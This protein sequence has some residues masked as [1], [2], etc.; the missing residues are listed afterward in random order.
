M[1]TDAERS[2]INDGSHSSLLELSDAKAT[3]PARSS[4]VDVATKEVESEAVEEKPKK[5]LKFW[6]CI[7]SIMICTFIMS[8]DL[9]RPIKHTTALKNFINLHNKSG[10]STA[11]PVIIHDLSGS[12]FEWVGSAYAL[13]ATAFMPLSG[14]LAGVSSL[15]L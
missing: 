6:M 2:S 12:Q 9:V 10:T 11:L 1:S 8:L 13:S 3:I 4:D 5:G 14:S 15:N 7:V